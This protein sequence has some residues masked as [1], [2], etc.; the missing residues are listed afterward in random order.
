[1]SHTQ[2]EDVN[3]GERPVEKKGF[4]QKGEG[5]GMVMKATQTYYSVRNSQKIMF[6]N[7]QKIGANRIG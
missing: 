5:G 3:V 2:T 6:Y 1:M 7:L 4:G